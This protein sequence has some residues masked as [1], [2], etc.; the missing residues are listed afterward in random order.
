[1]IER[2]NVSEQAWRGTAY[3]AIFCTAI[4]C[5][6]ATVAAAQQPSPAAPSASP[7]QP[8]THITPEQAK[9]L[10]SLVDVLMKFSSA[11][12]GLPIK[13]AVKRQLITRDAVQKYLTEKFNDDQDAKRLE[14]DEIVLKKFG[15]LD[16]DFDLKPFLLALLKEQIEAYY[17]AKTKTINLLDWVDIDEQKPVL[18]HELTHA[19]QD[20]RVGLEK[21]DDQTPDDVSATAAGDQNNL[22]RDEMDT[23]RDAVAEGQATAV[24]I[25]YVL[26]PMGKSLIKDPE[27]LDLVRELAYV[28][29]SLVTFDD[30]AKAL[31]AKAIVAGNHPADIIR[32]FKTEYLPSLNE[33]DPKQMKYA[34]TNF[35]QTA[36]QLVY[37]MCRKA[38]ERAQ[39]AAAVAEAKERLETQAAA[40]RDARRASLEREADSVEETLG[41]GE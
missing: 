6:A 25:D 22:A 15:L 40:E 14:R 26:K 13:S 34:G 41:G 38:K 36:D 31:L 7:A 19:L 17:D 11:E 8:A 16:R 33:Q 12:T 29:K 20:Q 32:V 10:F 18:A 27:V 39:E 9:Q 24:M 5:L 28:S 3:A 35:A 2:H 37:A 1:M 23:S 4:L 30:R 21:W